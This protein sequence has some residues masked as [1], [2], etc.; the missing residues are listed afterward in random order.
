[1]KSFAIATLALLLMAGCKLGNTPLPPN[2]INATDA[3]VDAVLSSATAAVNQYESDVKAGFVPAPSLRT[4][5]IGIQ[6]SLAI[7]IPAFQAWD[8]ALRTNPDAPEPAALSA[9]VS[10]IQSA[11]NTLP[12]VVK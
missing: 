8:S 9:A 7:A 1:M 10:A 5:M 12:T 4:T 2:A 6:K 3:Q 11:M